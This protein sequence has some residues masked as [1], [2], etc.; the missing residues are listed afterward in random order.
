MKQLMTARQ[1]IECY[2]SE[3]NH[4]EEYLRHNFPLRYS[5]ADMEFGD[6]KDLFMVRLKF[7]K[8]ENGVDI[9]EA[10]RMCADKINLRLAERPKHLHHGT[11]VDGYG[12]LIMMFKRSDLK[13]EDVRRYMDW[14][15]VE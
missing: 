11:A 12:R 7:I 9:C 6:E 15:G 3:D 14:F 5:G 10:L 4:G 2:L 13:E 8:D 1:A